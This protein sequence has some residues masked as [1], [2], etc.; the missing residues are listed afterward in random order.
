M[1]LMLLQVLDPAWSLTLELSLMPVVS[2]RVLY[3]SRA[4]IHFHPE[5]SS[6]GMLTVT[7]EALTRAGTTDVE[8]KDRFVLLFIPL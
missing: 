2:H 7:G 3:R 5:D 6:E 4:V 8:R 1:T